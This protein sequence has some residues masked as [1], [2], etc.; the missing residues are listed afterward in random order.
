MGNVVDTPEKFLIAAGTA[1]LVLAI[2]APADVTYFGALTWTI[3]KRS[4]L[5]IIGIILLIAGLSLDFLVNHL[6]LN[7][8]PPLTQAQQENINSA[9][10]ASTACA[11]LESSGDQTAS[12]NFINSTQGVVHLYWIDGQCNLIYYYDLAAASQ[13]LQATFIGHRW[14]VTDSSQHPIAIYDVPPGQSTAVVKN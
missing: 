7:T 6:L 10:P 3:L 2:I 4:A 13:R 12:V 11:V 14:L 5:G 1:C 8:D 9:A